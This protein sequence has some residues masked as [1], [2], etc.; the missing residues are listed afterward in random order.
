MGQHAQ[1][2]L[3][4]RPRWLD[5]FR[6]WSSWPFT[7]QSQPERFRNRSTAITSRGGRLVPERVDAVEH[8]WTRATGAVLEPVP[9]STLWCEHGLTAC[10]FDPTDPVTHAAGCFMNIWNGQ[11]AQQYVNVDRA[12]QVGREQLKQFEVLWPDSYFD[13]CISCSLDSWLTNK[14]IHEWCS[15]WLFKA[16]AHHAL[17]GMMTTLPKVLRGLLKK[18]LLLGSTSWTWKQHCQLEMQF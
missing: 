14:R 6:N 1:I 15:V 5:S 12:L 17:I 16:D 18:T 8:M 9:V 13:G 7:P 3:P 2:R 4:K 11:I 10:S